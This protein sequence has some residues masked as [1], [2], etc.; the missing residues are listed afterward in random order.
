MVW[1]IFSFCGVF[2]SYFVIFVFVVFEICW[3]FLLFL[4]MGEK[5]RKWE[6]GF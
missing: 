5:K 4:D 2:V 3:Y 1:F 6:V